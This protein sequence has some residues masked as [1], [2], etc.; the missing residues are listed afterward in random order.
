MAAMT[1]DELRSR[2]LYSLFTIIVGTCFIIGGYMM[3][4]YGTTDY[5]DLR[6]GICMVSNTTYTTSTHLGGDCGQGV[7]TYYDGVVRWKMV[8]Y[9]YSLDQSW[10]GSFIPPIGTLKECWYFGSI[11]FAAPNDTN[12]NS[13]VVFIIFGIGGGITILSSIAAI[14]VDIDVYNKNKSSVYEI[15]EVQVEKKPSAI[16]PS[17]HIVQ[18]P[19]GPNITRDR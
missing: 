3:Y 11:Q 8:N 15:P 6:H 16:N 14:I 4:H 5:S 12:T 17:T 9:N 18:I 19:G 7:C 2:L 10:Y 1:K 13:L